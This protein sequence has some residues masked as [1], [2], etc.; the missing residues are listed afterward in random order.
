VRKRLTS[1]VCSLIDLYGVNCTKFSDVT[2]KRIIQIVITRCQ[3]LRLK[4]TKFD[5][6]WEFASDPIGE[7]Y[8]APLAP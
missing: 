8:S 1:N 6:G 5:F 4:C 7:A 3:I 2:L